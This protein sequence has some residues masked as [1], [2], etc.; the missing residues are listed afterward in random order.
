M[1]ARLSSDTERWFVRRGIPH[2]IHA[3]SA[4]E[5]VFTRAAPF[6]VV[7]LLGETFLVFGDRFSGF[8]QAAAFAAGL[9]VILGVAVLVNRLRGRPAL[10]LPDDVGWAEIGAFVLAPVLVRQIAEPGLVALAWGVLLQVAILAVVFVVTSYG[11][12]PM[13]RWAVAHFL[14]RLTT[15]ASLMVRVLP[16]MLVFSLFLFVNAEVW[17]VAD[18]MRLAYFVIIMSAF[19]VIGL[20]FIA[21]SIDGET[22]DIARLESWDEAAALAADSP[23]ASACPRGQ[24]RP[25]VP[26]LSRAERANLL[27]VLIV[28]RLAPVIIVTAGVFVL[29]LGFGLLAI[30]EDVILAWIGA[31]R[32]PASSVL[33]EGS[34]LGG[35]V[36]LTRALLYVAGLI[37]VISGLQFAVSLA[38]EPAV[39]T[40]FAGEVVHEVREAIAA[41]AA[42]LTLSGPGADD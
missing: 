38:T 5:D 40:G 19:A 27:M 15:L 30:R 26:P 3:Y 13:M 39:R 28:S 24:A 10:S 31:D 14:R 8:G 9:A 22:G 42:Y 17:Q 7:V 16:L 34:F 11:I 4:T 2:F 18:D 21:W 33:W 12:V 25:E 23:M 36:V 6:L 35:D 1:D 37:S 41:R 20:A 29:Y 32:L